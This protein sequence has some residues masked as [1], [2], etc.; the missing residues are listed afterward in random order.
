VAAAGRQT[1]DSP[2]IGLELFK[3]SDRNCGSGP[4]WKNEAAAGWFNVVV[5]DLQ[6]KCLFV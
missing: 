5:F 4:L 6:D 3:D 2:A 1:H